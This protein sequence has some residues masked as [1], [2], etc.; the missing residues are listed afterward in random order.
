MPPKRKAAATKKAAGGKKAKVDSEAGP[1][2]VKTAIAALKTVDKG[3]KRAIK[4][5]EHCRLKS[6]AQVYDDFDCMLNQTNI[7]HNNNKYYVIQLLQYGSAYYVWT[8]WGRVGEPGQNALKHFPDINGAQKEYE[9]KFKDKT[10]NDWNKRNKF[11][12]VPGKYTLIEMDLDE[13]EEDQEETKKKLAQLDELDSGP[14][15]V[16]KVGKCTLDKPT[17]DLVK[18]IFDNDMFKEQMANF[19]LDV[20]KMPLGKLSKSQI[21]KGFEA[22][23]DIE[24][25]IN[26]KRT[27]DLPPLTSKFYTLIPHSFGRKVP[28]VI[29]DEEMV[30]KKMDM[31]LVL[32]DIELAQSMQK[33]TE[34]AKPVKKET[35]EVPHP[36]DVNY[37]LLKCG[38][39]HMDKGEKEYKVIQKYLDATKCNYGFWGGSGLKILDVW[40]VDRDG[41]DKR[42]KVH[43]SIKNRRLLWHGTN[44]A[45]VAA[46][47]KSGLRIMPHSGGRVGRGIYF[48]SEN[49][50]SAGYVG[51]TSKNVGI[52]FLNEVALG[53]EHE[54]KQG[55]GSLTKAPSGYDSIIARGSQEPDP[56][57]DTKLKFDGKDVIVPQ[58]KPIQQPKWK[59]S[60]FS[61][62]EYLI[63]KESQNRIRYLLKLQF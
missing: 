22:L 34:K 15:P 18:L 35:E 54:I 31:L 5:D 33:D 49:G 36:L 8:R 14:A 30:R 61:Q 39:T 21:A 58:G 24:K 38:L 2:D 59:A 40:E 42:F 3:K 47:L 43:D 56:S 44:V 32:G 19:E 26:E 52:M 62:S 29:N 55:N 57:K 20:K 1:S 6:C 46:I 25:A 41:E 50:K 48:A 27:K 45:V 37:E 17:Q 12:P 13:T 51:R 63:Y 23:E 28:P 4:V 53:R 16:K 7:G 9:K 60:H 10:K 11:N